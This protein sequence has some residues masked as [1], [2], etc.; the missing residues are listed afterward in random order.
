MVG[1]AGM[2][3]CHARADRD[4]A[5][6]G[7]AQQRR[8]TQGQVGGSVG[9]GGRRRR[10]GDSASAQRQTGQPVGPAPATI[11]IEGLGRFGGRDIGPGLIALA[12]GMGELG[13][14]SCD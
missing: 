10:R 1:G 13:S 5:S 3:T 4:K 6:S 11:G 14:Q 8:L 9:V 12:N 7:S 2:A